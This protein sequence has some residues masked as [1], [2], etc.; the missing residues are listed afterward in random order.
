M[1]VLAHA[2]DE[3]KLKED[4]NQVRNYIKEDLFYRVIFIW[5]DEQ[6]KEGAVLHTDFIDK[7][8]PLLANGELMDAAQA[9]TDAYLKYLWTTMLKDKCYQDWLGLKHSNA[10]QA[11]QDKFL[12]KFHTR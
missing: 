11:V 4:I 10:Y 7:C 9:E 8:K 3:S 12:S 1:M 2:S 5:D 6:L